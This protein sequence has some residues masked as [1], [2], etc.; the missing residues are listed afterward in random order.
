MKKPN[1]IF[2]RSC[3]AGVSPPPDP[4]LEKE[5]PLLWDYLTRNYAGSEIKREFPTIVIKRVSGGFL[6][7]IQEHDLGWQKQVPFTRFGDLA[8]ALELAMANDE[9]YPRLPYTSHL[10]RLGLKKF[11][12]KDGDKTINLRPWEA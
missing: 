12:R 11:Q 2:A 7:T 6:A 8:A 1:D 5:Q 4:V 3:V 10:N 9:M